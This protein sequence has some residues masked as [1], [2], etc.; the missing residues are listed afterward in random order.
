MPSAGVLG[1]GG[2]GIRSRA[3]GTIFA[4][5]QR[6]AE[7]FSSALSGFGRTPESSGRGST[8]NTTGTSRA[9][10]PDAPNLCGATPPETATRSHQKNLILDRAAHD[11]TWPLQTSL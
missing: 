8:D 7:Y 11:S 9:D 2:D 1:A 4:A 3:G 6:A 10:L 5:A